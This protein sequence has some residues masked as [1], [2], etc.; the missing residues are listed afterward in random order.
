MRIFSE[1]EI[2]N[3]ARKGIE[4]DANEAAINKSQPRFGP[5]GQS[6]GEYL[7]TIIHFGITT[8]MMLSS[9]DGGR[10]EEG[11]GS[12]SP[13]VGGE[14]GGGATVR[15]SRFWRTFLENVFGDSRQ[16]HGRE[17][18]SLRQ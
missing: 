7:Q 11:G 1:T 4:N 15:D 13:V 10:G 9:K 17:Q 3:K 6:I 5:M 8:R 18:V 2:E 14:G 16:Y 12:L